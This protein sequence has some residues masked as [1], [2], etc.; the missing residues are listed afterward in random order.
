[1]SPSRPNRR[2]L[3]PGLASP[4]VAGRGS[5]TKTLKQA[6]KAGVKPVVKKLVKATKDT[7][8]TKKDTKKSAA[9][10]VGKAALKAPVKAPIKAV[11]KTAAQIPAIAT[12]SPS[13]SRSGKTSRAVRADNGSAL[14]ASVTRRFQARHAQGNS[15]SVASTA[16]KRKSGKAGAATQAIKTA[17]TK[18]LAAASTTPSTTPAKATA[19]SAVLSP[20]NNHNSRPSLTHQTSVS[21]A[22]W[23]E[24]KEALQQRCPVMRRIIPQYG[25]ARLESRGDAYITLSRSVVGQQLSVKAAAT[26]WARLL[27]AMQGETPEHLLAL[28]EEQLRGCGLSQRKLDYL[29]HIAQTFTEQPQFM[30]RLMQLGDQEVITELTR[31]RGIGVWTA[32]MFLIFHMLRP[33]VTPLDDLGLLKAISRNYFSGEPTSRAEAREVCASWEPW[34]TLGTW[35]MWRSLDPLPVSY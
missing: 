12:A 7:K 6:K 23:D 29:R 2:A 32:E 19:S 3:S 5:A 24:A 21:P 17:S 16:N 28:P 1:M 20:R 14:Y 10:S 9:K 8:D 13:A 15:V 26:I 35:Y 30:P 31:L 22:W 18:S 27:A 34:G 25:Q 33:N 11:V 4:V